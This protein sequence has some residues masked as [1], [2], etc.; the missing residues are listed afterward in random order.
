[1]QWGD[2]VDPSRCSGIPMPVSLESPRTAIEGV[3]EQFEALKAHIYEFIDAFKDPWYTG[4]LFFLLFSHLLKS[5]VLKLLC[6]S[7]FPYILPQ[8]SLCTTII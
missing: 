7:E 4:C 6:T 8:E 5:F 2:A 1:M 3:R